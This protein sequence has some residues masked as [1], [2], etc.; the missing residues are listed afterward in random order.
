[1][2]N[3]GPE[4]GNW[5]GGRTITQH[6]YVLIRVGAKHHLSDVRGYAYEHRIVAEAIVGRRLFPGEQIHHLNGNRQDNRKS[7][8]VVAESLARHRFLHRTQRSKRLRLPG[9][10]NLVVLCACG[11]GTSLTIYDDSGRPRAYITGHNTAVL[12]KKQREESR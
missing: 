11:C 5:K 1:M 9:E 7:N 2:K 6:G 12:K 4:N 10:E 3:I 8:I